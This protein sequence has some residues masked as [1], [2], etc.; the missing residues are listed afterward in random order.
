[1]NFRFKTTMPKRESIR[2][3]NKRPPHKAD[4]QLPFETKIHKSFANPLHYKPILE[5][6]FQGPNEFSFQN[7]YA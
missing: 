4:N 5:D 2:T 7:N 1:M 6:N 3:T